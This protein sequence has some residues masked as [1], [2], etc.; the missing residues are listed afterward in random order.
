M[1]ENRQGV[2]VPGWSKEVKPFRDDS[3]YWGDIWKNAGRPSHGLLYE[4]YSSARKLYHHAVLRVKRARKEYQA[5]RLLVASME[6]DAH[7]LK[8]I[9][10]IKSGKS[11]SINELPDTVGGAE[12][13][14]NIADMFKNS[15]EELYNSSP[16]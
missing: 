10:A 1:G 3:I 14:Q 8:S 16:S 15:Y 4:A 7:L 12:G 13:K 5:E 9:R 2:S 6:G 11:A